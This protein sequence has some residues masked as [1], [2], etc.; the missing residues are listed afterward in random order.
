[1]T[2]GSTEA[3]VYDF[4]NRRFNYLIALDGE[5]RASHYTGPLTGYGSY[6]DGYRDGQ[7]LAAWLTFKLQ[8]IHYYITIPFYTPAGNP[9]DNPQGSFDN[10]YWNGWVD[11][12]LSIV[13]SNRKGFY[14]SLEAAGQITKG[15][16][17]GR[18]NEQ[19]ISDLSSYVR[20][21]GLKLI[22]IP[23][24]RDRDMEF[25]DN[26]EYVNIPQLRT[27]FNYIFVQPNYYQL[28]TLRDKYG[29]TYE[30]SYEEL[31]K[32]VNWIYEGQVYMEMEVDKTVLGISCNN[33]NC[34][35]DMRCIENTCVE[36][37]RSSTPIFALSYAGDYLRAQ[38][39]V[40]GSKF[41]HRAYY[42]ST[43][44]N[45]IDN[46]ERYCQDNLGEHYV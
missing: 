21:Y 12:V 30:Y 14:W 5:G 38:K 10:S 13:D 37:C 15:Y 45:V 8:G 23:A 22:W 9:R 28:S 35:E 39:D 19:L 32:R 7:R 27:Y 16:G 11:G 31:K 36:N 2:L 26:P 4:K 29:N 24:L 20:S 18:V 44:L 25:I 41:Y 43:D 34:P 42:F 17:A 6:N 40:L 1:M 46:M 3:T 33:R